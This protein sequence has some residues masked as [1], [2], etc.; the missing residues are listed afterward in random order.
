MTEILI[1]IFLILF[2]VFLKMAIAAYLKKTN[3]KHLYISLC[4]LSMIS[5]FL[6]LFLFPTSFEEIRTDKQTTNQTNVKS[7]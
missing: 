2:I 7:G 3:N 4:L 1:L 6:M 5:V